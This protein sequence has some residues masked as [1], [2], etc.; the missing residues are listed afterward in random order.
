[1]SKE[2]AVD[3]KADKHAS[4]I[5]LVEKMVVWAVLVTEM[6]VNAASGP[7]GTIHQP[8]KN[9][10]VRVS[11]G[12]SR[13]E[14]CWSGGGGQAAHQGQPILS[15]P[16]GVYQGE[17]ALDPSDQNAR[18][19][20]LACHTISFGATKTQGRQEAS[21]LPYWLQRFDGSRTA[22]FLS[23]MAKPQPGSGTCWQP[24]G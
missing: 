20:Q 14:T 1:M 17:P 16:A 4:F 11:R 23:L 22:L 12:V 9:Q 6:M 10:Q 24:R 15:L 13:L 3:K 19:R 5:D 21:I 8:C 18:A 2:K 7:S